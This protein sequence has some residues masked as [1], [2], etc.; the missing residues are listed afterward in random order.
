MH[1]LNDDIPVISCE[2]LTIFSPF[3]PS[4]WRIRI[5]NKGETFFKRER[6]RERV[7]FEERRNYTEE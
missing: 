1:S 7:K 5:D 6:E 2:T 3:F 4:Y